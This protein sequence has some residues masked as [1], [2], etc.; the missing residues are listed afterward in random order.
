MKRNSEMINGLQ[1]FNALL[2]VFMFGYLFG[3]W[4]V[5]DQFNLAGET[6]LI[7]ILC[8]TVGNWIRVNK[9]VKETGK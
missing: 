1:I 5:S 3:K 2:F 6:P 4:M 9:K 7:L 8:L